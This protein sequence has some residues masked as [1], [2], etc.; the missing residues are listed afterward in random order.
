MWRHFHVWTCQQKFPSSRV[1][2]THHPACLVA[3]YCSGEPTMSS[4]WLQ[5]GVKWH[6]SPWTPS[7]WLCCRDWFSRQGR[8]GECVSLFTERART[9]T[10]TTCCDTAPNSTPFYSHTVVTLHPP[11]FCLSTSLTSAVSAPHVWIRLIHHTGSLQRIYTEAQSPTQE[12][13]MGSS[14]SCVP[15]HNFRFSSKSFIRRNR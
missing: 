5:E 14:M 12:S 11:Y 7:C 9:H 2:D 15:Q 3:N 10:H 6:T 4:I 8:S 1:I 13:S